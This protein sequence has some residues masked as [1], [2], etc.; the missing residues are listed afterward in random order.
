METFSLALPEGL[1]QTENGIASASNHSNEN[2]W[3]TYEPS[4]N[5]LQT[6]QGVVQAYV[7]GNWAREGL[8][9]PRW[10]QATSPTPK[11]S[12]P[13]SA[14]HKALIESLLYTFMLLKK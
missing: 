1:K 4:K 3:M 11:H 2:W 12:I 6:H 10:D 8:R 13:N 7:L 14:T 5:P 9:D